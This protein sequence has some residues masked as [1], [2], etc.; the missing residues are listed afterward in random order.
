M[1]PEQ[2]DPT[3]SDIDTRTDVYSLGVVLYEMLT[4]CLPF[5]QKQKMPLEE[6]LR[7]LREMEPPTPSGRV[8]K[9]TQTHTTS[10]ENRGTTPKQLVS[11]LK[12]DLDWITMR[13]LEKDRNRRYGAPSEVA[14]DIGR[15][16]NNDAILARPASTGYRMRKYVRRHRVGVAVAAGMVMVLAVFAVMQAIQLR[17]ITRERDRANRITEF[18]TGMFKVSDP[19]QARGNDIRAREILDKASTQIDTGLAKDPQLQAQ[20]MQVMGEVYFSLGLYPQA[21][22]LVKRAIEIRSRMLGKNNQDTLKSQAK[23]AT[24]FNDESHFPE[25]EKL[26]QETIEAQRRALGPEHRDTLLTMRDLGTTLADAGRYAEAEKLNRAVL[27][28]S[29]RKFGA[30]DSLTISA[31]ADL[32]IDLAYQGNYPEAEEAFREVLEMQRKAL[33][34]DHPTVLNAMSN[35][36]STLLQEGKYEDAEKLYRETLAAKVRVLGPEHPST[37]LAMGNLAMALAS[38]KRYDESERLF[39]ETLE[40][41]RKRLGPEHRSTL[42]TEGNLADVLMEEKKYP[43]AEQLL[44]QTL[45]IESRTLGLEH[46]DTLVTLGNL[47]SLLTKEGHYSEAEKPLLEAYDGRRRVIGR[48]N[49]NTAIAARELARLYAL[50]GRR[51][52]AFANLGEAIDHGLAPST[53]R[54][55]STDPDL[56][57]LHGD[58]RFDALMADAAQ[59]AASPAVAP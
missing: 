25:A 32:A 21:E 47:G 13:A 24:I 31:A 19:S 30:Q 23:L 40:I 55:L 17:R 51:D 33:G 54:D 14:A 57:S 18:M 48:D 7:Q 9:D 5:A 3:H 42:V 15:Y 46:S 43:E 8:A 58:P 53:D 20:M 49:P 1:S 11:Q 37:L 38:E 12:G 22:S 39:R 35:L 6:K 36:G 44:R 16:L 27:E 50:E 26:Q 4:G 10:A 29:R 45:E 34:P 28:A 2:A 59:R 52:D 56:K 41:K